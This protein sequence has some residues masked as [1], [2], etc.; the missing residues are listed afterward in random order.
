MAR[1]SS[2]KMYCYVIEG[3][4][5]NDHREMNILKFVSFP[6][7]FFSIKMLKMTKICTKTS[8]NRSL[9]YH[10][11]NVVTYNLLAIKHNITTCLENM[12]TII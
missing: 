9:Q 12:Y 1:F 4:P 7:H 2:N 11:Y 3:C 5:E 6:T 8:T 10:K